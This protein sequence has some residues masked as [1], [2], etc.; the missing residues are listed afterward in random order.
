MLCVIIAPDGESSDRLNVVTKTVEIKECVSLKELTTFD[1]GGQA[2]Y[3]CCVSSSTDVLEAI[4]FAKQ[5]EIDFFVLGGGSNVVFADDG[6]DGL[7]IHICIDTYEV[8]EKVVRVGA[9]MLLIDF[10]RRSAACD[11][12]GLSGMAGIPG[13]VGGAVRG[14]AGAFGQEIKD[15]FC[16]ARA[17]HTI[18]GEVCDFNLEQCTFAYRNSFFKKNS[19]YVILEVD[20]KLVSG[21]KDHII[22]EI[23]K[24]ISLRE[25][26]H[27]QDIRSAGSFFMNP[28]V[29]ED[30]QDKFFQDKGMVSRD[31]RVPAG[32]LLDLTGL[33]HKRIGD[34]Q[35]GEMHA[36]YFINVGDGNAEQVMQLSSLAKTRV[37]DKYGVRLCEEV[38]LVGF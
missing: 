5:N 12:G 34:I 35:A 30:L 32:W 9:G 26:K 28:V 1:I 14:N 19:E 6:F 36:N 13:S 22:R 8:S 29:S 11:L 21:S 7:V 37:R 24:T 27:I 2:R 16:S 18:T 38:Q 20:L 25:A 17:L 23:E 4:N 10:L 31:G 15:V 3:Y 33:S